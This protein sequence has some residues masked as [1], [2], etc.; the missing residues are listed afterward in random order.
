MVAEKFRTLRPGTPATLYLCPTR[1]P[2]GLCC[3][4]RSCGRN[5]VRIRR[6]GPLI[7]HTAGALDPT[8][9]P[10]VSAKYQSE[11]LPLR[12]G[13]V[14]RVA[15]HF[16]QPHVDFGEERIPCALA[17]EADLVATEVDP[18]V[19]MSIIA[20]AFLCAYMDGVRARWTAPDP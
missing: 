10:V 3:G 20:P 5:T 18:S 8:P 16:R 11:D 12:V 15:Q 6:G 17:D 9:L 14:T 19:E 1:R 2:R 4:Q 13:Q 7:T